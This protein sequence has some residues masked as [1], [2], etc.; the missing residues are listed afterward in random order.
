M[1]FRRD[2]KRIYRNVDTS[3]VDDPGYQRLTRT[4]AHVLLT[5]RICPEAGP[6]GIMRYYPEVIMRRARSTAKE[7]KAALEELA[8]HQWVLYDAH[9]IWIRDALSSAA[10]QAT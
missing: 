8:A 10:L 6:C 2:A 5:L 3:L 1:A 9:V 7:V 4:A